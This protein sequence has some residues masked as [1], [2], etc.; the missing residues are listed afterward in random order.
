MIYLIEDKIY[1][2][3]WCENKNK[4]YN[5]LFFV[6]IKC[7]WI[8]LDCMKHRDFGWRE[9][10]GSRF[11]GL[12]VGC[13]KSFG[14]ILVFFWNFKEESFFFQERVW[15]NYWFFLIKKQFVL[16]RCVNESSCIHIM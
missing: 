1:W 12:K 10:K 3:T 16:S 14:G 4:G 13:K 2:M 5:G 11:N 15:N 9:E 6:I 8:V 7:D